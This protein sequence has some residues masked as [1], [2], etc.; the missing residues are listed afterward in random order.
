M[1]K[2]HPF[3]TWPNFWTDELEVIFA[4]AA[5]SYYPNE[6]AAIVTESGLTILDNID[7]NPEN[8][9]SS[10]IPVDMYDSILGIIHS[11]PNSDTRPSK[12]DCITQQALNVP[13]GIVSVSE[14]EVSVSHWSGDHLLDKDLLGRPFAHV[15]YDCYSLIRAFYW[16]KYSVLLEDFPR[17]DDWWYLGE[18]LYDSFF[19]KA[20]FYEVNTVNG[21]NVGD[22]IFMKINSSVVNH[23][24]IYLGEDDILHHLNGRLSRI[25]KYSTWSKIVN[26]VVRYKDFDND[27]IVGST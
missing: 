12:L 27:S 24:A 14:N 13:S 3:N 17:E 21:L 4:T 23:A 6:V 10:Y 15:Y 22:V 11:H 26:K 2:D 18:D 8:G 1:I 5:K 7:D 20:G 9:Y 19:K 25:D 16:Q